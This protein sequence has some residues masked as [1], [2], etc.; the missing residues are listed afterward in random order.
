[1]EIYLIEKIIKDTKSEMQIDKINIVVGYKKE[2]IKHELKK[3]KI[4]YINNKDFKKINVIFFLY[5]P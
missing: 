5:W 2:K 1:M 3:Y 4:D